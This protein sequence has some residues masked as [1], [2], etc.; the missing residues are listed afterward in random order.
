V[1]IFVLIPV[2][3]SRNGS[4]NGIWKINRYRVP[5]YAIKELSVLLMGKYCGNT[6][7]NKPKANPCCQS[8]GANTIFHFEESLN[9]SEP[10]VPQNQGHW[11]R[12]AKAEKY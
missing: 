1:K 12:S 3:Y 6:T 2:V 11:S 7:N 4:H 8:F 5:V 9:S 10:F